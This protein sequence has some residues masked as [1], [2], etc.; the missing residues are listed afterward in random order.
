MRSDDRKS[1]YPGPVV[2][3]TDFGPD[4]WFAGVLRGVLA[5]ESPG[6]AVI[7]LTHSVSPFDVR[8][9]SYLLGC[10][11]PYFPDGAIFVC[12]VD[13]GVGSDREALAVEI[14]RRLYLAPNNGILSHLLRRATKSSARLLEPGVGEGI[15]ATF[16]GRDL[17][18]PAAARIARG[19][20]LQDL[21]PPVTN[22]F[23]LDI[24]NP[25]L[26]AG[27]TEGIVEMVDAFGNLMTNIALGDLE[28]PGGIG[29]VGAGP[30]ARARL[31]EVE[32]PL[33]RTYAD[34]KSGE[35]IALWNSW[36]YLEIAIREGDAA[37]VLGAGVG[38]PVL[39]FERAQP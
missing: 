39:L 7:D 36:G 38:S 1:T 27:R 18:V 13:P 30:G 15:S 23:S 11:A 10:A 20:P 2:L 33:V 17:F 8:G 31:G 29:R 34:A 24:E 14:D 9:G 32:V 37:N 26:E 5:A 35:P 4:H 16:H 12:V 22:L 3:M 28:E 19:E 21:G 25:R 6:S